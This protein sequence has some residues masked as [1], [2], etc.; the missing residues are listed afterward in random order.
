MFVFSFCPVDF[1][2]SFTD[3]KCV[4]VFAD[5]K[6]AVLEILSTQIAVVKDAIEEIEQVRTDTG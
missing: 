5:N 6:G 2:D 3:R 1:S 4:W